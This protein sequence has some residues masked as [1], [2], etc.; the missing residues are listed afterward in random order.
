MAVMIWSMESRIVTAIQRFLEKYEIWAL[1]DIAPS[2][3][4]SLLPI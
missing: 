1:F 2:F 4:Y 3:T